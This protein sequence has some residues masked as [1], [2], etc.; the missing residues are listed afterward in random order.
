MTFLTS[1]RAVL[2]PRAQGP[3]DPA[4]PLTSTTILEWVGGPAGKAGKRVTENGS[5]TMPAV[6]RAVNLIA[7]TCA[8][9]PLHAYK[10]RGP[11]RI[12]QDSG[13]AA[14][15]LG[16]PHPDLTAFELWELGYGSALTWGN[17]AYRKLRDPLGTIRELWWIEPS[18]MTYGRADDG[19]KVYV[20]DGDED[21]PLTDR[22]ILHVPG[23]GYDGVCGV[24]AIRLAREGIG[25]A[26]A[27]EEYGASLFGS[28]SLA[29]GLLTT[30]QRIDPG[31]AS[32]LKALWKA[33]G[34]G[35]G[36]DSAHDIRVIGS[37]AKFQQLTIPPADT[38][39]IE[40]RRFQ[41]DEV[42]RIF[43]VPPHMLGET[44]KSTSWGTGIE[45][46]NIG[47][48]TYT[49]RPWLTRFEQRLTKHLLRPDTVYAHY[50]V[51]GLLRGNSAAR[52]A[53]YRQLWEFGA[54]STNDIRALE[55]LPPVEGGDQRFVPLN[56]G[57]L[58]ASSTTPALEPPPP[59][60]EPADPEPAPTPDRGR[61]RVQMEA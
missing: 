55:E 43:G 36:L 13:A 22:E 9:M 20:I 61:P 44:Q 48:V 34:G 51:E 49:L 42:A 23:F 12:L 17:A 24:S 5:L 10:S 18:R 21:H 50:A 2:T 3:E 1:A 7:G 58:V 57:P 52:S 15:L 29:S 54:L 53:F 33:A 8:A 25:L 14:D 59:D 46:Q 11:A 39:F 19:S 47:F 45:E 60:P 30:E 32:E 56:F 27:A 40:S 6:W 37:G 28:G 35:T 31:K 38:Q 41:I 4:V 16:D 26:L